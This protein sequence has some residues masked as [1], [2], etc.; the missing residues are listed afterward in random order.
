M[1]ADL[2]LLVAL[3]LLA[4]VGLWCFVCQ[5]IALLGGWRLLDRSYGVSSLPDGKRLR[6]QSIGMRRVFKAN[7]GGCLTIVVNDNGIGLAVAWMFR[8]GHSPLYIP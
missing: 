7:Y 5:L 2:A 1:H 4:F 8:V 6:F 3:C